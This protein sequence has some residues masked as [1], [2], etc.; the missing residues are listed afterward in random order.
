M[1]SMVSQM[2][3]YCLPV[4]QEIVTMLRNPLSTT[5]INTQTQFVAY[6]PGRC[7]RGIEAEVRPRVDQK[8]AEEWS[9]AGLIKLWV[10][11]RRIEREIADPF[12][13]RTAHISSKSTFLTSFSRR[14]HQ[15]R[16]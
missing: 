1:N 11:P 2:E 16:A 7:L 4:A 12:A 14:L 6:G 5:V 3:Y 10:L 8:Y 9:N 15:G 13:K